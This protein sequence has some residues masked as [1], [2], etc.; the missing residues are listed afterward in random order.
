M[1]VEHRYTVRHLLEKGR[2]LRAMGHKEDE[3]SAT[4]AQRSW[5]AIF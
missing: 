4:G 3:R 2:T 5:S 1:I